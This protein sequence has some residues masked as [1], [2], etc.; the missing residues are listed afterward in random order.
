[1]IQPN[2]LL[3]IKPSSFGDIIHALPF[4]SALRTAWPDAKISWLVK[5]EW[6]ELLEG[7][8]DLHEI[9]SVNFEVRS[10]RAIIAAVRARAFDCVVDLQGLLRSSLI[11]RLSGAPV[12]AGFAGG[13]EG[14]PWFYTHRVRLPNDDS[15]HWRLLDTHMVDRNLA[16]A[17]LFG[18][19]PDV[20]RF[21]LPRREDDQ[22]A[23]NQLLAESGVDARDRLVAIVPTSRQL[24]KNWP[25]ERFVEVAV[26]LAQEK[27]RK[28]VL[29]GSPDD[30]ATASMFADALGP[31]LVNLVGK[32]R[33]RQ[34]SLVFDKIH[35][36]IGN[37]SGPIHMAAVCRVPVIACFGATN[38]QAAA[39]YGAGHVSLVS[40]T[41]PCRPCGVYQCHNPHYLDCMK[42]ITVE[43]VMGW[44]NHLLARA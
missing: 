13:R 30:H 36:C 5:S 34:L 25:L 35:L 6:A 31:K 16:V 2:N 26:L 14:S 23:V 15:Q 39:P 3:I 27:N 10:W 32:T 33:I 22:A 4:V 21:W 7:H 9:I 24:V 40:Q 20:P 44:A 8:P 28:I 1:M 18:A 12:R 43:E 11:A 42:A 37:D 41:T 17:G 29:L 38:P 19:S